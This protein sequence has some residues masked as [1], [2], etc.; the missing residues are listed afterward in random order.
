MDLA[1]HAGRLGLAAVGG[2][3][4]VA[5]VGIEDIVVFGQVDAVLPA[6]CLSWMVFANFLPPLMSKTTFTTFGI[7]MELHAVV[8]QIFDHRQHDGLV[9]VVLGEAQR[10]EIRQTADMVDISLHIALHFQRALVILEG[11]HRAP[12]QPEIGVKDL[13]VKSSVIFTLPASHPASGRA[14]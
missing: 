4:N 3:L 7:V 1:V 8:L 9:L 10:R 5:A 13:F 14:S 11:E 2:V 6:A 12:V